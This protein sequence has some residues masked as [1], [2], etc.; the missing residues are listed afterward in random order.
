MFIQQALITGLVG[1][2]PRSDEII[3]VNPL[4]P[5]DWDYFCIDT[6]HYHGHQLAI[7]YDKTGNRYQKG[8]GLQIYVDEDLAA[9]STELIRLLLK[10]AND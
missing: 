2:R 3:E 4:I 5:E 8:K 7:M 1:L 6:I 10:L 9:H